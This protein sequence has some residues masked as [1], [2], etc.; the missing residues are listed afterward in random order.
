M[1]NNY[2]KIALRNLARQKMLT[3]INVFGLSAGLAC[4]TLFLL[5]AGT[6]FSFDRLHEKAKRIFRVYRWTE[7]MKGDDAEGDPYLP[8]PLGPAIK[9]D[10]A[11]VE[12]F[13]RFREAWG[14][15]FIRANNSVSR[16]GVVKDFHFQSLRQPIAPL[17]MS[18]LPNYHF[19]AVK[20][21]ANNLPETIAALRQTVARFAPGA[22]FEM[23]F[24]DDNFAG[25]YQTE[26]EMSEV[27]G[28]ISG[29][30]I[31]IA[32]LG[33]FGLA[34]FSVERRTKEIGVRKVLGA[35][36]A[37]IV[38]LLSKDFLKLVLIANLLSWPAAY[39]AM[40]KWLQN[41]AYRIDPNWWIFALA[42]GLALLIALLTVST[43]AIKAALANPVE[44][45]RYE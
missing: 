28:Y 37:S 12:T 2:L 24:L 9:H 10:F 34:S 3:F 41:F 18:V 13:V 40:H 17:V 36:V 33:L 7:A 30:A 15:D 25:L 1:F 43:Q 6:E 14:E 35:S 26:Q 4:F 29:L 31:F 44:A 22:A 32:C 20:A 45:L 8:M 27:F 38:G 23:S 21:R 11:D 16:I 42:G 19:I 39:F 5:Y